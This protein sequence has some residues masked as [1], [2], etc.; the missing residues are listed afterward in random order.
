MQLTNKL[1]FV[2]LGLLIILIILNLFP[3]N[4]PKYEIIGL[5]TTDSPKCVIK[6]DK[7]TGRT[8][9]HNVY[10]EDNGWMELK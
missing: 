1:L 6:L 7:Q 4:N 10:D 9:W 8:W 5:E 3:V 2:V